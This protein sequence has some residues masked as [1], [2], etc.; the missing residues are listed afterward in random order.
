MCLLKPPPKIGVLGKLWAV[1]LALGGEVGGV[2][3]SVFGGVFG[4]VFWG[5]WRV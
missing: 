2:F 1:K 5:L 3:G 4:G